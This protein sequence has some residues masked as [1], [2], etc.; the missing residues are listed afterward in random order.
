MDSTTTLAEV[1]A[2][3]VFLAAAVVGWVK[4]A[5]VSALIAGGLTVLALAAALSGK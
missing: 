2:T 5:V 3:A 4:K 1:A